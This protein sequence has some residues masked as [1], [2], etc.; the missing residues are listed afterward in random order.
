M[1]ERRPSARGQELARLASGGE[2]K[3]HVVD[4]LSALRPRVHAEPE[5]FLGVAGILGQS[6]S[7]HH[8]AAEHEGVLVR[9]VDQRGDVATRDDEQMDR[10]LRVDVLERDNRVVLLH[11]VA[12]TLARDDAAEQA[13]VHGAS[14]NLLL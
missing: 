5:A 12:R 7:G 13:V 1:G 4:D 3:V 2:V 9:R 14:E 6:A 8:T 11:D 10:R